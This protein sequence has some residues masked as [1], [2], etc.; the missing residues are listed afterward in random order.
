MALQLLLSSLLT[1]TAAS[2]TARLS[3]PPS[4]ETAFLAQLTTLRG[5]AAF[6][7]G[8]LTRNSTLQSTSQG[9]ELPGATTEELASLKQKVAADLEEL[10]QQ[11]EIGSFADPSLA[12]TQMLQDVMMRFSQID[13]ETGAN[14]VNLLQTNLAEM[15]A[16]GLD[17]ILAATPDDAA[18]ETVFLIARILS[19]DLPPQAPI[20]PPKTASVLAVAPL[21]PAL[22]AAPRVTGREAAE[23]EAHPAIEATAAGSEARQ[24]LAPQSAAPPL[25]LLDIQRLKPFILQQIAD[26]KLLTANRQETSSIELT[27]LGLGRIE[28]DIESSASGQ[29]R[30]L[31]RVEN[32]LVLEALRNDRDALA[33]ALTDQS[34][35]NAGFSFESFAPGSADKT[36]GS[37][38]DSEPL[39]TDLAEPVISSDMLILDILA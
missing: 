16:N 14:L 5:E 27:P 32:P 29:L 30:L 39:D 1:Q 24:A 33:A 6:P 13:A 34:G 12:V 9:L 15:N 26:A 4:P 18:A 19:V 2:A 11:T 8:V 36:K 17:G 31:L 22:N 7:P 23:T 25:T 37:G 38:D 3:Q 10:L 28:L 21:L 20:S 35:S